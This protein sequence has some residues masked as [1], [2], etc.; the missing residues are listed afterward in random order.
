[1]I[2]KYFW[3]ERKNYANFQSYLF[4]CAIVNDVAQDG[5]GDKG[6]IIC[7]FLLNLK[8][9]ADGRKVKSI[10]KKQDWREKERNLSESDLHS[11]HS[12]FCMVEWLN[13]M[14]KS[15]IL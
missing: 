7:I 1:M 10:Y 5:E 14:K 8:F 13:W 4:D 15:D 2:D 9:E 12:R 6:E 11:L 3:E